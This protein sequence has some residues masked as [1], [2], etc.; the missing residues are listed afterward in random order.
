MNDRARGTLAR[1]Q[2]GPVAPPP[3]LAEPLRTVAAAVGEWPGVQATVH[4]HLV[5]R[6]RPDGI[7][8]YVGDAELGHLHLDGSIHLATSPRLG[9]ALISAGLAKP[10]RYQ[11]GW[12]EERVASIG[13]SDAIALFRRN[14]D[15]LAARSLSTEDA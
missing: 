14:Y 6:S 12:V 1:A 11:E 7:D 3:A 4:W 13:A 9:H 15:D 5:D 8:F 10:F 2:K